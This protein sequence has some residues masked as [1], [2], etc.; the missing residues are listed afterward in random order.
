MN[1]LLII[2]ALVCFLIGA[3]GEPYLPRV[4]VGWLGLA[5]YM[6]YLLLSML[7]VHR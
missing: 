5:F 7:G 3:F 4:R 2:A 1:I 6:I